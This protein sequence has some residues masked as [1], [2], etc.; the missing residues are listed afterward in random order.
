MKRS[1]LTILVVTLAAAL[2]AGG[3]TFYR[4]FTPTERALDELRDMPLVGVALDDHPELEDR[5]RQALREEQSNPTTSGPSR[6]LLVVGEM[7]RDVIAPV[8]RHADDASVVA[9][10]AARVTLVHYLQKADP[11][12]CREF[13][14]GGISRPDKLDA[15]A[16]RLFKDVLVAMEAAYRSGRSGKPQAMPTSQQMGDMMREAGFTKT[17]FDRL[18]NFAS[19]SNEVS[20]EM[21]L[22]VDAAPPLLPPDK[23]GAF[24]RFV[25]AR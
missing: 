19:L 12:A 5:F 14:M 3:Y 15:E 9:A 13:S 10:M 4:K 7:R 24:S 22:K 18:N 11:P 1:T 21:E 16:Q 8:L 20:C 23:R 25:V 2:V 17:D 6:A